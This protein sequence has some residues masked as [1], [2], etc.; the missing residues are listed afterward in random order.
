VGVY[1]R[2]AGRITRFARDPGQEAMTKEK[3]YRSLC[4]LTGF[5]IFPSLMTA[6]C[7]CSG[8]IKKP[9]LPFG[10]SGFFFCRGSRI[11]RGLIYYFKDQL[12]IQLITL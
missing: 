12:K 1:K 5:F 4:S 8:K 10:R 7:Q 6:S 2:Y 3:A 9:D 11:R